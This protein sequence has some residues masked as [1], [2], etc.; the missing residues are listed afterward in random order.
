MLGRSPS[1]YFCNFTLRDLAVDNFE[2]I[3]LDP[4]LTTIIHHGMEM[5]WRMVFEIDTKHAIVEAFNN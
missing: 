3:N 2:R 1:K 5:R 4:N